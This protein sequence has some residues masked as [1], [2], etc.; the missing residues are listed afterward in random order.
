[1]T[2]LRKWFVRFWFGIPTNTIST[3][4][5]T[6]SPTNCS[7]TLRRL[8]M[9]CKSQ[10]TG[11]KSHIIR[12]LLLLTR[13]C[14]EQVTGIKYQMI[15]TLSPMTMKCQKQVSGIKHHMIKT[16][17]PMT[18]K[19]Q[20]KGIEIIYHMI[21]WK[22]WLNHTPNSCLLYHSLSFLNSW[23]VKAQIHWWR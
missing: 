10:K 5:S 2:G 21:R 23:L 14:L 4:A 12:T 3:T 18:M 7:S 6:S 16:L 15:R 1:M 9:N 17:S 11:I 19:C 8:T 20:K 22:T 13:R